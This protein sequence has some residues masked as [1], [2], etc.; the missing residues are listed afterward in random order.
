MKTFK[1]SLSII[2]F[3]VLVSS[4]SKTGSTG[5][6]G[7]QGPAGKNGAANVSMVSVSVPYTSW[8]E[9]NSTN[10][11]YY[12]S[13]TIPSTDVCEVYALI[14][15]GGYTPLPTIT[16]AGLNG[17]QFYDY[18]QTIT[19]VKLCYYNSGGTAVQSTFDFNIVD[20]PPS[21]QVKYPST[22]W[23]NPDEVALLP[24]VAAVLSKGYVSTARKK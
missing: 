19:P 16:L 10:W 5:P 22:N 24:E 11:F 13:D 21:I 7:P 6:T 3:A 15:N 14:G 9:S 8:I 1:L 12:T 23:T 18:Y 2:L 17:G 4:C 20:I